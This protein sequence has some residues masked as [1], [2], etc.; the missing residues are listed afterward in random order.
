MTDYEIML[1]DAQYWLG[2]NDVNFVQF[3]ELGC[4]ARITFLEN[5]YGVMRRSEFKY[6]SD[7]P[8]LD[9]Y[10]NARSWFSL[11]IGTVEDS[12]RDF[13]QQATNWPFPAVH[14]NIPN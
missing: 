13:P 10:H 5:E 9:A 6:W 1:A 14:G 4:F 12:S 11:L 2:V 7:D 3:K 8:S